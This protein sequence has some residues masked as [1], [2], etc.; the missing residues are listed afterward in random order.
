MQN[1][2]KEVSKRIETIKSNVDLVKNGLE[3]KIYHQASVAQEKVSE[4]LMVISKQIGQIQSKVNGVKTGL[5]KR[6][7][8]HVFDENLKFENQLKTISQHISESKLVQKGYE[9]KIVDLEAKVSKQIDEIQSNAKQSEN[10][11]EEKIQ[12]HDNAVKE[13]AEEIQKVNSNIIVLEN[14]LI[15]RVEL[16]HDNVQ[17]QL[18]TIAAKLTK[19]DNQ[20]GPI[21]AFRASSVKDSGK[22]SSES[23]IKNPGKILTVFYIFREWKF[24]DES[25]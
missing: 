4:Q 7:N 25:Y 20:R 14:G 6:I 19:I 5:D 13:I 23:V 9:K 12:H 18:T 10:E 22:S 1:Q 17:N 11:L 21:I 2:F 24:H 3:K 16:K 15:K 8:K